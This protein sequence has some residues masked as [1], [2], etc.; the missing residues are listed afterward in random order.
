M[1]KHFHNTPALMIHPNKPA[2]KTKRENTKKDKKKN[3]IY[4]NHV[5]GVKT[6]LDMIF[7]ILRNQNYEVTIYTSL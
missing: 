4:Y 5:L 7:L 6:L 2:F 1:L 3:Y